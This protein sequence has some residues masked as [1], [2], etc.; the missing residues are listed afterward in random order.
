MGI[1]DNSFVYW[2]RGHSR[3]SYNSITVPAG[4]TWRACIVAPQGWRLNGTLFSS[5]VHN[6]TLV[7]GDTVTHPEEHEENDGFI[8]VAGFDVS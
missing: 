4:E 7:A 8:Y 5:G 2:C 1:A 6:T 3:A